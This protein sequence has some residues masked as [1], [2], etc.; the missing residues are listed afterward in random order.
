[1]IKN[2]NKFLISLSIPLFIAGCGG[3]GGGGSISNVVNL[4]SPSAY[5]IEPY[6]KYAWHFNPKINSFKTTN[7]IDLNSHINIEDAWAIT[8]GEYKEGTNVNS[9]VKIAVIDDNFNTNHEDFKDSI[10]KQCNLDSYTA[11]SGD[12]TTYCDNISNQNVS[13]IT[14][15]SSH[16]TAV[17][18]FM[19]ARQNN[20]G[21]IGS[22]FNSDLIVIKQ[23]YVNDA[24]TV[25]AFEYAKRMG[26]KVINCSWG[27]PGGVSAAVSAKI[28]E[29]K[30]DG[31]TIV[32][33]AGNDNLDMDSDSTTDE[34]ELSSVI[35]V[36]SSNQSNERSSFSN[37]ST[38]MDI[39][40]PGGGDGIAVLSAFV[41]NNTTSSVTYGENI[42]NTEY[43][44]TQGTSFSAP[45]TT[46]VIAL[47][48]SVNPN[49]T[50]DDIRT[51]LI[52]TADKIESTTESYVDL[53]GDGT[54][55]TFNTQRAYG[56]INA[57]EAVKKAQE[58]YIP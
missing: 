56:K 20:K 32:F 34:S 31:I 49:L 50:P 36:G 41:T 9:P 12:V 37:Y 51:I 21:L 54:S 4:A 47:M 11:L 58:S 22:A 19:T 1:M 2:T 52:E 23:Q 7:N 48:I 30:D 3:G 45:I 10:V 46:G 43:S 57:Y 55:S 24:A 5:D 28:Q 35:S 18:N 27:T 26:A 40:A 25:A 29:L 33:A 44:F 39:I 16:G 8:T 53:V 17:A 42:D 14:N 13:P 6:Y 38:T 15:E